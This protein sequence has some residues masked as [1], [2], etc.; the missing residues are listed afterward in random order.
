MK[1]QTVSSCPGEAVVSLDPSAT[2]AD[3]AACGVPNTTVM[4][5]VDAL[6]AEAA[7]SRRPG[8][9]AVAT[10]DLQVSFTRAAS[11]PLTGSARVIGGGR[12]VCF[13]EAA[14]TDAEGRVAAQAMGTYRFRESQPSS[15][16][17]P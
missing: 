7:R 11:G 12:S 13:C 4:A 10:V 16:E 15:Q 17:K 6:M 14:L 9:P 1:F 8:G 3:A 5:L 2:G